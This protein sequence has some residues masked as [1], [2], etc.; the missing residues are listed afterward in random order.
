MA[1]YLRSGLVVGV[2]V[3]TT[4]LITS[5][6]VS[7][8]THKDAK[9]PAAVDMEQFM[10]LCIENGTPGK[11]H[12][13]LMSFAGNWDLVTR[14]WMMP[15]SEP[16]TSKAKAEMRPAM[17]GRFLIEKVEGSFDMGGQPMPFQGMTVLGYDNFK[18]KYIFVWFDSMTTG[19]MSGE[20]THDPRA[21]TYTYFSEAPDFMKGGM[22]QVK[23]VTTVVSKDKH[24]FEMFEKDESGKWW[25][26]F[27]ISYSRVN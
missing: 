10:Q 25:K 4:A 7:Q 26:N 19:I 14:V 27:D 5:T 8:Q 16:E 22:K 15:G 13:E 11:E 20:G 6:V 17:D 3:A 24:L 9:Q 1:K 23:S 18:K 21:N 2:A 12:A